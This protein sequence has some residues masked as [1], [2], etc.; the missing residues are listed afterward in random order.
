MPRPPKIGEYLAIN[1]DGWEQ[2][3]EGRGV[4]DV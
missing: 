3:K 2:G 4:R 1:V